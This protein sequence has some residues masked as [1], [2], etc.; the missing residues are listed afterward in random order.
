MSKYCPN[1]GAKISEETKFCTNCGASTVINNK[2]NDIEKSDDVLIEESLNQPNKGLRIFKVLIGIVV[3][4]VLFFIGK[5]FLK[6]S[7]PTEK[8][9]SVEEQLSKIEGKWH[10]P[11]G[12]ILGDKDAVIIFSKKGDI[13]IGNDKKNLFEVKI[14]PFGANNYQGIVNLR[15]VEGDFSVHFYEEENKL[16]FFSTFTKS[17]WYLI[18]LKN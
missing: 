5:S 11:T 10:D 17:S 1:C 6:D 7:I 13:I 2:Q 4:I 3:L 15:G 8:S 12:I 14:T 16:V 18:K 9:F